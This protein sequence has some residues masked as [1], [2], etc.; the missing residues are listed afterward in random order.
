[1]DRPYVYFDVFERDWQ[2]VNL[3]TGIILD[4][5]DNE[6]V[7]ATCQVNVVSTLDKTTPGEVQSQQNA[8]L[9][10]KLEEYYTLGK[11]RDSIS[12]PLIAE[13]TSGSALHVGK[14]KK[15]TKYSNEKGEIIFE[16]VSDVVGNSQVT[17]TNPNAINSSQQVVY[18]IEFK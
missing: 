14:L 18:P 1:M 6:D 11:K 5:S 7:Y 16:F 4:L 10:I 3:E 13:V 2:G 8:S 12:S 9:T 17:V 15:Q